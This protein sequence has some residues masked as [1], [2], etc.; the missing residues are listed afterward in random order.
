MQKLISIYLN[1]AGALLLAQASCLF[2]I[3]CTSPTDAIMPHDPIFG[4]PTN[5]SYWIT[6]GVAAIVAFMCLYSERPIVP[7]FLSLWLVLT[8]LV[9]RIGLWMFDGHDL[10]GF[11]GGF[12]YTFGVPFGATNRVAD[13]FYAYLL[14]GSG[15]TLWLGRRLPSPVEFQKMCCPACGGHVKFPLHNLGQKIDCPHCRA[16]VALRNPE[17]RLKSSCFFC[18]GH[19]EFPAHAL[20]TKMPCPHCKMDITLKEST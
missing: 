10:T 18:Q 3:N 15:I 19:I 4:I 8:Y 6:G 5:Y 7:A 16:T 1:S 17:E 14:I 20:G 11:L 13:A 12:T 2:L 9:V